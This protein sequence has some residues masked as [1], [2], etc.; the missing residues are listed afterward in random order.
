MYKE[1]QLRSVAKSVSWRFWA[2]LTTAAIVYYFTKELALAA[3]IGGIEIVIKFVISFIHERAWTKITFGIREVKPAVL[4]FT[5]LS[6]AGKSTLAEEVHRRMAKEGLR[7]ETL[8]GDIV[9][10]VFPK[11]GFSR[12]ER[13]AHVRRV[14]FLASLLEKNGVFVL[15]SFIAPYEESRQFVRSLCSDFIEIHVA[16]PLEECERRD[17]KGRYQKA[18]QGEIKYF[19]GI[20]DPYEEPVNP[21]LRVDTTN[22]SIGAA[23]D[24]V[25]G[26][27]RKR[28]SGL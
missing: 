21:E 24:E 4:W 7:V 25:M 10:R 17:V 22:M 1:S 9:R 8:D 18:R 16:T 19:T 3:A 6:G 27:L 5:G 15:A 28:K 23:A 14:G 26:L 20:D 13:D 12:P 11:T 2:T